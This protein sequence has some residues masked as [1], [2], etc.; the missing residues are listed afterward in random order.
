MNGNISLTALAYKSLLENAFIWLDLAFKKMQYMKLLK[1][2]AVVLKQ[3]CNFVKLL[4][5][6][7]R[8][9]HSATGYFR[10]R[11]ELL[12][13][14]LIKAQCHSCRQPQCPQ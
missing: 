13:S 7:L 12:L 14:N 2:F 9:H 8:N 10:Y 6:K 5:P 1:Y 11:S 3:T 4:P